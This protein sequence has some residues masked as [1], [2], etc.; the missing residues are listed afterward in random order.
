MFERKT[1]LIFFL[2]IFLMQVVRGQSVNA[3]PQPQ[4]LPIYIEGFNYP[5][6]DK[7]SY[8]AWFRLNVPLEEGTEISIGGEHYR[9]YLADR[10]NIPI[11]LKH[12]L[13]EKTYAVGGYQ[14]EWD[15]Y[16][17]GKGKPNTRPLQEAFFGV[18]YDVQ[19]NMVLDIKM[20]QPM[21]KPEFYKVGLEGVKT[22]LELGT[23]LKFLKDYFLGWNSF[24]T[25][26]R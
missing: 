23:K 3:S 14:W 20:V 15:L 21:I 13:G 19:P 16:N 5:K 7:L 26:D 22:R 25:L 9:N 6:F 12:Y 17:K 1:L 24:S 18:G 10:F 8:Y 4:E 2:G 11:Q